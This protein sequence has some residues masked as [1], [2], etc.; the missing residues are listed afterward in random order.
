MM[1]FIEEK[2]RQM[3]YKRAILQTRQIPVVV[4][5]AGT[6]NPNIILVSRMIFDDAVT[7]IGIPL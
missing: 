7:P 6:Q 4:M 2:A 5:D 1:D 3:N